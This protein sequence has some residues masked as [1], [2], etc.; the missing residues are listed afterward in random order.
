MF[1][2]NLRRPM[3]CG[4]HGVTDQWLHWVS[5]EQEQRR[6]W[7]AELH[8]SRDPPLY[9][10][11]VLRMS[12]LVHQLMYAL[13]TFR[14]LMRPISS[15]CS[16]RLAHGAWEHLQDLGHEEPTVALAY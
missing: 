16:L 15:G 5:Q 4:G 10:R 11:E 2:E 13:P 3:P 12:Q 8:G 6:N 9:S 7:G 1:S 14:R